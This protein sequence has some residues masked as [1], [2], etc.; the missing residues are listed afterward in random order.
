MTGGRPPLVLYMVGV[1][2]I[3]FAQALLIPNLN[4][5]AMVPMGRI[6]GTAA[7]VIG[8]IATLGGAGLGAGIDRLYDGTVTPLALAGAAA[9]CVVLVTWRFADSRWECSIDPVVPR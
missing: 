4:S 5:C 8:S 2:P 6:A 9:G 3:L 1:V 7:A